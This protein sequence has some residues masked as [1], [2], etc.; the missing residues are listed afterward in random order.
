LFHH[1]LGSEP[2]MLTEALYAASGTDK[3]ARDNASAAA[4]TIQQLGAQVPTF[5]G[6]LM[7]GYKLLAHLLRQIDAMDPAL[8]GRRVNG[9][10]VRQMALAQATRAR[11]TF[12][13]IEIRWRELVPPPFDLVSFWRSLWKLNNR[14]AGAMQELYGALDLISI[15]HTGI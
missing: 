8:A 5:A 10:T 1:M 9:S 13:D 6:K 7:L 11:N 12:R 15:G 3:A 4:S 14:A 2:R